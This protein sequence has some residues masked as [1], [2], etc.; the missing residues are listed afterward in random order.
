MTNSRPPQ[1][2]IIGDACVDLILQVPQKSGNA[3][4]QKQPE[5]HGGGTGA[6]HDWNV[7]AEIVRRLNVPVILAGGLSPANVGDAIR[8]V[9]PWCVDSFSHT[10]LPGS[11]R[12]DP[13]RVKAFVNAARQV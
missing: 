4:Q 10:N 8:A 2:L 6:T 3:S 11:R 5:L 13:V 12:K 7:G 9:K 1:V